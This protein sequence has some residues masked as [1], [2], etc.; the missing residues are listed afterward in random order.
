MGP[1]LTVYTDGLRWW[2]ALAGLAI[3]I[4]MMRGYAPPPDAQRDK[5]TKLSFASFLVIAGTV[6]PLTNRI[7]GFTQATMLFQCIAA[8][9]WTFA[10][11]AG[12]L[13]L[14][15]RA[16]RPVPMR[17]SAALLLAVSMYASV[18]TFGLK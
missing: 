5:W 10:A 3:L 1:A 7:D 15:G 2:G 9:F 8:V 16:V 14:Q 4:N 6:I 18:L 12:W 17:L 13:G 11:A